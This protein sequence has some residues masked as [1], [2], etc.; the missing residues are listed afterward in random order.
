GAL[1]EDVGRLLPDAHGAQRVSSDAGLGVLAAAASESVRGL[2]VG[3]NWIS[4]GATVRTRSTQEAPG[5]GNPFGWPYLCKGCVQSTNVAE[6]WNVLAR[7]GRNPL[8]SS[9]VPLAIID[10]GF[11]NGY[12]DWPAVIAQKTSGPNPTPCGGS[13]CPWHGNA[14]TE[15]A[16]A[17]TDDRFGTAGVAG[18]VAAPIIE[19]AGN[20]FTIATS[21]VDARLAGAR[22]ANMSFSGTIPFAGTAF[23][24]WFDTLVRGVRMSGM[25]LFAAA[26]NDGKNVDVVNCFFSACWEAEYFWPCETPGVLCVGALGA[27]S[28]GEAGFSNFGT[29]GL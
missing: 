19:P 9:P 23:T 24:N 2:D 7:A 20:M 6:A 12:P 5:S 18:R 17:L 27:N 26:G 25:V 1:V 10:S 8:T 11:T 21:L 29:G 14:V 3:V 15:T 22:I 13:P 28:R 16:L 4:Y